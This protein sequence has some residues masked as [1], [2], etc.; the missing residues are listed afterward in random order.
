M[1]AAAPI[2]FGR[3]MCPIGLSILR[4]ASRHPAR[5]PGTASRCRALAVAAL[6][7]AETS[8]DSGVRAAVSEQARAL[9]TACAAIE[10]NL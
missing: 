4:A 7:Q 9:L 1:A 2:I 6:A 10:T 5:L 3:G 8:T